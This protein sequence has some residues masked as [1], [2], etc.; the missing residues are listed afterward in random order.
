MQTPDEK[1]KQILE[2]IRR[3]VKK[4]DR[5]VKEQVKELEKR[6]I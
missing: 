5:I 2:R 6:K 1:L 4:Y 3:L